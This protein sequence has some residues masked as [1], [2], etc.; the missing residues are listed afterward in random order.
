[1]EKALE[2]SDHEAAMLAFQELLDGSLATVAEQREIWG[3]ERRGDET[4]PARAA[5]LD[6]RSDVI[7]VQ[8]A[9]ARVSLR[10]HGVDPSKIDAAFLKFKT[11]RS[12]AAAMRELESLEAGR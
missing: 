5:E 1:M 11:A 9:E 12:E 10:N 6:R 8:I 4:D 2:A 3:A 7:E